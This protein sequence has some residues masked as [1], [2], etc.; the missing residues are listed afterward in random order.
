M[1]ST[2]KYTVRELKPSEM[3]GIFPLISQLNPTMSKALFTK[4]LRSMLAGGYRAV[5][6]F[7][8][9]KMVALSGFWIRTRFWCGKQLDIDNVVVNEAH[10]SKG[11]GKLMNDWLE[12]L[13]KQESI[14]LIVLDSYNTAHAAHAFYHRQGYGITGY[15]FTKDPRSGTPFRKSK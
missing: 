6:V 4:R 2:K 8:G 12:A 10:R 13:A 5:A 3:Q 14:E 1:R 9:K 11:L 7:E 15:H